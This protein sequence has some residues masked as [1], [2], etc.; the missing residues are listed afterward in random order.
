MA[1][2][3]YIFGNVIVLGIDHEQ[4]RIIHLLTQT[5]KNLNKHEI[6]LGYLYK[7]RLLVTAHDL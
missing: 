5:H 1:L 3:I 4:L 2:K 6:G 7:Y